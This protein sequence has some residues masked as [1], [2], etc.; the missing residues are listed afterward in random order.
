MKFNKQQHII[1]KGVDEKNIYILVSGSAQA[2][3]DEGVIVID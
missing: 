1:Q 2:I 3:T